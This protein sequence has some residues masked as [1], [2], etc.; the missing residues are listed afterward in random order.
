[1]ERWPR[2]AAEAIR[3]LQTGSLQ[4]YLRY[5]FVGVSALALLGLLA[6]RPNFDAIVPSPWPPRPYE[7]VLIAGIIAGALGAVLIN[8]RLS[9]VAAMGLVGLGTAVLFTLY[10]AP[11]LAMTQLAVDT[12]TLILFVL[13]FYHLPRIVPV[14]RVR[15]RSLDAAIAVLV[16]GV[17]CVLSLLASNV[18]QDPAVRNFYSENAYTLGNGRNIVNVILVDFRGLDTLGE[19]TVLAAAGVGVFALLKYRKGGAT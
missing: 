2:D 10:G 3:Y 8:S 13:V 18:Q 6:W 14:K 17:F 5:V 1:M 7:V 11:D 4:A 19:I 9:A 15:Q 16:G 12:L